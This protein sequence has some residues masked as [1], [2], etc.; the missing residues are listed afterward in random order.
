[1]AMQEVVCVDCG[2][3]NQVIADVCWRCLESL[4]DRSAASAEP[5]PQAQPRPAS[6]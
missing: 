2:A 1:M 5:E 4:S 6:A 3:I